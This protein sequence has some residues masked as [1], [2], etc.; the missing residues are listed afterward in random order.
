MVIV[1][2][3]RPRYARPPLP[4]GEAREAFT[5]TSPFRALA[6][7]GHLSQGERQDVFPGSSPLR[8][9]AALGHLSQRERQGMPARYT[10]RCTEA[11]PLPV[12]QI[13]HYKANTASR[14]NVSAYSYALPP[15]CRSSYLSTSARLSAVYNIIPNVAFL[16]AAHA[17][18][19]EHS[20]STTEQPS[21]L[22]YSTFSF[23]SR[24]KPSVDHVMTS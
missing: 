18:S 16:K 19:A 12:R 17:E 22:R 3:L 14:H 10:E 21:L 9:L 15:Q 13:G 2:P 7:L 8:A 6:A 23:V 4:K 24:K 11:R 1:C 5:G 20:I